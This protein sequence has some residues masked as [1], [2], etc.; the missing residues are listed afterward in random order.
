MQ[1][2]CQVSDSDRACLSTIVLSLQILLT[3]A[4]QLDRQMGAKE[5][6]EFRVGRLNML[7]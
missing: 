3:T 2:K 6:A 7:F 1:Q 4:K 5:E